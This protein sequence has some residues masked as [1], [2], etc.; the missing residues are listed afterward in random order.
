MTNFKIEGKLIL[1]LILFINTFY[2]FAS[3]ER[4]LELADSAD[5]LIGKEKWIEAESK[6]ME[7]LRLEPA[8]FNNSLL[9]SNLGIVQIQKGE[10]DKAIDSFSL[11]LKIAP[12]SSVLLNNRAKG[13][14]FLEKFDLAAI[15]LDKSLEKDSIQEWPIQTRAFIYLKEGYPEKAKN[16]FNFLSDKFPENAMAHTGMAYVYEAEGD[17]ENAISEYNRALEIDSEDVETLCSKIFLLI[18]TENYQEARKEISQA[19]AKYPDNPLFYLQRGYLHKLN[20]RLNEAEADRKIA[21]EKGLDSHYVDKFIP[22]P[23]R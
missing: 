13:Y 22:N 7:A 17:F 10:Y 21:I 16:L 11:G 5:Y 8:N 1:A 20:F 19:L 2:V 12:S 23:R 18:E 4:Y 3:S 9:L 6:I 15:D 14:L